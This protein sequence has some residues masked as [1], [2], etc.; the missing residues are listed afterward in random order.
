MKH[1]MF[2]V[3]LLDYVLSVSTPFMEIML[4][5]ERIKACQVEIANRVLEVTLIVLNMRDFD[6]IL[7]MDWLAANY[8]SIDYS[9]KEVTFNPPTEASFKFRG[10][11]L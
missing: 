9:R 11:E 7:G 3:E 2:E 5:K 1:A 6:V 4:V 8:A 10:L